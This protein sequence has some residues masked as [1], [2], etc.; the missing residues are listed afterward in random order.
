ML[1]NLDA[2]FV[3]NYLQNPTPYGVRVAQN[4]LLHDDDTPLFNIDPEQTLDPA[5]NNSL[6]STV[7]SPI[8]SQSSHA[9]LPNIVI[10]YIR[11]T[12]EVLHCTTTIETTPLNILASSN[13]SLHGGVS[14]E[15][16]P[17]Y[18]LSKPILEKQK[19]TQVSTLCSND[20]AT[21]RPA[22]PRHQ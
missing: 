14:H 3:L 5:P 16:I 20:M 8:N 1:P 11:T 10:P 15:L 2:S 6:T 21:Y 7:P 22:L 18:S 12:E 13:G 4:L 19:T 17:E 9:S